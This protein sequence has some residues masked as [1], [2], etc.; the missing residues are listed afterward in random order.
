MQILLSGITPSGVLHIGNYL[1]ALKQWVELQ[2][3]HRV[4]AMVADLHAITSPQEPEKLRAKTLEVASLFIAAGIEPKQSVIFVQSHVP[5]HAELG[6]ILNTLTP[7]GELQ[8][9]T[10]FKEKKEKSGVLSGLLTYPTLMA[11]DILLYRADDVPVGEDQTQHV[12]LTRTLAE[13]FNKRFGKTFIIPR[14]LIQ[15]D[16]A[17]VMGLDDPSKKMSKSAENPNNYVALLDPPDEI[18]RKIKIAVTDSGDAVHYDEAR[19]PGISNLMRIFRA[20]SGKNIAQIERTYRGKGYATF[21]KDL[22]E[23]LVKNLAPIQEKYY[24]LEKNSGA[25]EKILKD[26]GREAAQSAEKTLRSA[27]EKMGFVI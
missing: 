3:T 13:K 16:T 6:W 10:Q 12:E 18:R 20:F 19:K 11:A 14:P 17:R 15:K 22:A 23:L 4:F 8:R 9:M 2:E 1:G 5:A 7:V 21:K 27:K 24:A 26:G 25:I